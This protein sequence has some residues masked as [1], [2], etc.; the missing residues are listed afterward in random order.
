MK[1]I[2]SI[3]TIFTL[4]LMLSACG[5]EG[6]GAPFD[7]DSY[8]A[9]SK[10]KDLA[11]TSGFLVEYEYLMDSPRL[12]MSDYNSE[13]SFE[14]IGAITITIAMNKEYTY[15]STSQAEMYFDFSNESKLTIISG[16]DNSGTGSFSYTK[17]EIMYSGAQ[18]RD[19]YED[20]YV[21]LYNYL[22][23]YD[24]L[25]GEPVTSQSYD[26]VYG[27]MC[28]KYVIADEDATAT[29]CIDQESGMCLKMTMTYSE[30]GY[31][32]TTG[33]QCVRFETNPTIMLP[34]V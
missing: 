22:A 1:K 10:I 25:N 28:E 17:E 29:I 30:D 4:C 21:S 6:G 27:R 5:G 3:F 8:E 34:F 32:Y 16:Y 19:Y 12:Y 15:I 13:N 20:S 33:L 9:R 26:Y 18:N 2:L 11:S 7:Y 24:M 23:P 14:E 31:S